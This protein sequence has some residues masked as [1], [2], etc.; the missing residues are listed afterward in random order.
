[1]AEG[2][3]KAML[4]GNLG[5]DPEL[6]STPN[7]RSRLL[8]SLA[9]TEVYFD[10]NK[11]KQEVTHWHNV[12]L[13]G[14]RAEA[15]HKLLTKGSRLYI[16]GRIETRSYEDKDGVKKWATDIAAQN[17]ILLDG[18]RGDGGGGGVSRAAADSAAGGGGGG[19]ESYGERSG[20]SQS[21]PAAREDIGGGGGGSDDDIP[22]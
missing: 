22:F 4:I 7:G 13:W 12:V 10:Q 14:P 17:L 21:A 20:Q 18:R 2:L 9:T 19:G 6:R 1:M 8:L 11:Q 3:N 16:E 15:L 5:R